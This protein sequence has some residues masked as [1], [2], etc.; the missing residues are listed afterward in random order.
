MEIERAE[1]IVGPQERSTLVVPNEAHLVEVPSIHTLVGGNEESTPAIV[2]ELCETE[3]DPIGLQLERPTQ[4][5]PAHTQRRRAHNK[6][7]RGRNSCRDVEVGHFP[8]STGV[9]RWRSITRPKRKGRN[10]PR[11]ENHIQPGRSSCEELNSL[12]TSNVYCSQHENDDQTRISMSG[13]APSTPTY[14][15]AFFSCSTP[16]CEGPEIRDSVQ[17][18]GVVETESNEIGGVIYNMSGNYSH[19]MLPINVGAVASR[20][21]SCQTTE[22]LNDWIKYMVVPIARNLGLSSQLGS[23]GLEKLFGDL[24]KGNREADTYAGGILKTI[25]V[26]KLVSAGCRVKIWVADWFA[27]LNNKMGGD[28][29]KIRTIGEYLIEIWKAAGMNLDGVEFLWSS[30]EINSRAH[31]YWPLVMDIARRNK[32]PRIVRCCQIM[33]RNEQDDLSAAQ[34][35][36]PCM[37][38]ADIFFLKVLP[39]KH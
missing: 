31:E 38:C 22:D 13:S 35:F 8:W 6:N 1:S 24:S 28:L 5:N 7:T 9:M 26:N 11:K 16:V 29:K 3:M 25:N 14:G 18:Q 15:N 34:I 20:L 33:G 37:Q 2:E 23:M 21:Y 36:Y 12:R 17:H 30:D 19:G 10:K 32:L 27:Q 39:K 4:Q